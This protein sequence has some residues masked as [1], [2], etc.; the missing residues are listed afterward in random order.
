MKAESIE[1][2]SLLMVVFGAWDRPLKGVSIKKM[3]LEPGDV[4]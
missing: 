2:A 4:L 3:N 1:A